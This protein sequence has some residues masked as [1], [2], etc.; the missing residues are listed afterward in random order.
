M[1]SGVVLQPIRAICRRRLV[2]ASEPVAGAS[3]PHCCGASR[4]SYSLRRSSAARRGNEARCGLLA[5]AEY[6]TRSPTL[7][8]TNPTAFCFGKTG[9]SRRAVGKPFG[10]GSVQCP[11]S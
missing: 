1:A 7:K 10:R 9:S 8:L 5:A 6:A 11:D 3:S 4:V 2:R